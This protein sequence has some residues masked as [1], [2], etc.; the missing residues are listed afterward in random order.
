MS[1]IIGIHWTVTTHGAW[2]HGDPRG[3]WKNDRLIGPDPLLQHAASEAMNADAEKLSDDEIDA[4][5][6][7]VGAV[8]RKGR[9]RVLACAVRSTHAHLVF[10]PMKTSIETVIGWLWQQKKN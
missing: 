9:H 1:D 6:G 4:V 5:A 3:S 2:L 8:C 7:A 10:A